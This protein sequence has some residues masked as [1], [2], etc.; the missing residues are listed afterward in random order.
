MLSV[1]MLRVFYL[2]NTQGLLFN[3]LEIFDKISSFQFPAIFQN[4]LDGNLVF[5]LYSLILSWWSDL[6]GTEAYVLR[7]LSIIFGT[8]ACL[9]AFSMCEKPKNYICLVLF[10]INSFLI[11]YSQQVG[12][13]SFIFFFVMLNLYSFLKI[14][15][16]DKGYA[17]WIVSSVGMVLTSV[18]TIFLVL[19]E[20]LA[21][22][23]FKREDKT[24]FKSCIW[25]IGVLVPYFAYIVYSYAIYM[26]TY[27]YINNSWGNVIVFLQNFFS[28]ILVE[29]GGKVTIN[30]YIQSV[31]TGMD[32][33]TLGFVVIPV[34]VAIYFIIKSFSKDRFNIVL[35]VISILYIAIRVLLQAYLGIPFGVGEYILVIPIMLIL[36]ANG[37]EK[38][39]L[40]IL[41][42][43]IYLSL[44]L[45]YL[46]LF[47]DSAFK[48]N[49]Q[50]ILSITDFL[51][52]NISQ[53]DGIIT[54]TKINNLSSYLGKE[55][56]ILDIKSDFSEPTEKELVSSNVINPRMLSKDKREALRLYFVSKKYPINTVDKMRVLYGQ[57]PAN[58][59]LFLI[60]RNTNSDSYEKFLENVASDN[61]FN[62]SYEDI[63]QSFSIV[64]LHKLISTVFKFEKQIKKDNL[65]I[66]IYKK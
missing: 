49:K 54:W 56:V 34:F 64:Q 35:F 5:S 29:I 10:A 25:F 24:F 2:D 30:S 61:Y 59:N 66:N 23:I 15:K 42:F 20:I 1:C 21:F 36:L 7:F 40:S 63:M 33:Y 52:T 14:R 39:V 41:L 43:V 37:V 62:T 6:L 19:L 58:G 17:L 60:Y 32:F 11:T 45:S 31:S 4:F 38:D 46:F 13:F 48:N 22:L 55:V 3:E 27:L 65:I 18:F 12:M 50:G 28:P 44:N 57:V 9:F 53:G 16:D 26:N 51:N 47:E 8:I